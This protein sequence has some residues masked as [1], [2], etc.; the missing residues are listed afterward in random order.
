MEDN[1]EPN[2]N[3][4]NII[5]EITKTSLSTDI[6]SD[7]KKND[8]GKDIDLK[9]KQISEKFSKIYKLYIYGKQL[10]YLSNEGEVI[11]FV[12]EIMPD[13]DINPFD[14][15][16]LIDLQFIPKKKP[17]LTFKKDCFTPSF[18]DSRNLI[19]CFI[20]ENLVFENDWD[21][22]EKIMEEIINKGIKNF[23]F[24][25]KESIENNTF[26]YFGDYQLNEIYNIN[27]FL[28]NSNI[29]N[30]YRI[31]HIYDTS[32]IEEKYIIITQ[33]YFLIFIPRKNYQ[34]F[35][36][37]VFNE[38]LRDIN[39]NFKKGYNNKLKQNTLKLIFEE[40]AIPIDN[41]YEIEFYFIDRSCPIIN[42]V[43]SD[44]DDNI[45]QIN[46]ENKAQINKEKIF[47]EKCK[48]LKDD[49]ELKQK[50]INFSKYSLVINRSGPLFN[51]Y[52]KEIK[53]LRDIELKNK[54]IDY[55]KL[56]QFCE[57][58]FY[59]YNNLPSEEKQK[60]KDRIQFHLVAIN[61]LAAELM[62]FYDKEKVNFKF[63]YDKIKSI[64]NANEKNL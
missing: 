1:N 27:D 28:E 26:I 60:F 15:R 45:N 46:I 47:N 17:L 5:N 43:N 34:S 53:V 4:N 9:I 57:K 2:K 63:Y 20:K 25:L 58:I 19:E 61:F 49:I 50:E 39:I 22:I 51:I 54:I 23:L 40:I 55:E 3:D 29:I 16:L 48:K 10:Y 59:H 62:A 33:L 21:K 44:E 56:F 31:N 24:C 37:L 41:S 11:Y 42:D 30:F 6:S 36:K 38:K 64:L 8:E 18:C 7:S 13:T 52:K 35:G 12:I 32:I 14:E